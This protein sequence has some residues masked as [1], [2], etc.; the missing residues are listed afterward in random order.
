MKT[1]ILLLAFAVSAC[2]AT[3]ERVALKNA[4]G[5]VVYCGPYKTYDYSYTE[6]SSTIVQSQLRG[7]VS[8]FQRQGYERVS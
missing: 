8:D 5:H 1:L 4:A 3:S 2:S 7:C 6:T